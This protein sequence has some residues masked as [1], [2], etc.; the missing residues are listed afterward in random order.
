[1]L[2]ENLPH[3]S[4]HRLDRA[5]LVK[6]WN[7]DAYCF[8]KRTT[9]SSRLHLDKFNS[10]I[11]NLLPKGS[12][13]HLHNKGNKPFRSSDIQVVTLQPGGQQLLFLDCPGEVHWDQR[14]SA[15]H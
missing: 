12:F 13:S 11:R 15:E 1:M 2:N 3:I 4:D 10:A 6:C 14:Y 9:L 7:Y 8:H 5:F